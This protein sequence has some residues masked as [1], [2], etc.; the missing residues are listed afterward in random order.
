MP[1]GIMA[2]TSLLL[3]RSVVSWREHGRCALIADKDLRRDARWD[4]LGLRDAAVSA[5]V[6]RVFGKLRCGL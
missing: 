6:H 1:T 4:V 3:A 5:Y 2:S